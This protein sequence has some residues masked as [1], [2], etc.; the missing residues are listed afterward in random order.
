M[1]GTNI[2]MRKIT[3][4]FCLT[5]IMLAVSAGTVPAS[6]RIAVYQKKYLLVEP[7]AGWT[8]EILTEDL[9]NTCIAYDKKG[10]SLSVIACPGSSDDD[11]FASHLAEARS[12]GGRYIGNCFV[13][14]RDGMASLLI[15]T[16]ADDGAIFLIMD[17][18][19]SSG[20]TI[21]KIYTEAKPMLKR[22][23]KIKFPQSLRRK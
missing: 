8:R 13:R 11:E 2:K 19:P 1:G 3:A 12:A 14:T 20:K 21:D 23:T 15:P 16:S 7:A 10:T 17:D 22:F 9:Y 18:D 5:L 4:L 6:D